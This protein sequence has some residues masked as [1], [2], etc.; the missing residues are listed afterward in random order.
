ME[1]T[2][3]SRKDSIGM[4]K[5]I[6]PKG[7]RGIPDQLRNF[8]RHLVYSEGTKTEP[9]YV[10]NIKQCIAD[11]YK[12][13]VNKIELINAN[14]GK[15]LTTVALAKFAINDVNKRVSNGETVDHV[16]V[17]YDKDSFRDEKY[18][19]AFTLID[20]LNVTKNDEGIRCDNRGTAW[21]SLP[22]NECF[23]LFLLLYFNYETSASSRKGYS[24]K[25]DKM[26]QKSNPSF[27]YAKNLKNIHTTLINAGGSINNAIK[28]AK[29]LEKANWLDNP[30]SKAYQFLEYFKLY[31]NN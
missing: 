26:V 27:T 14:K 19:K 15:S 9:Y 31:L 21:H 8:G 2:H 30:S 5:T 28:F 25:I 17:F 16:W 24:K 6:S 22:S 18:K 3:L 29:K 23:E 20:G 11:K 12:T 10:D 4:S 13:D 7:R 1:L